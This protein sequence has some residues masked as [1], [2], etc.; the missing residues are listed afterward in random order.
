MTSGPGLRKWVNA[1]PRA[2]VRSLGNS[3][4]AVD[5]NCLSQDLLRF[6]VTSKWQCPEDERGLLKFKS[7]ELH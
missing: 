4:V 3:Q 2:Q 1:V 5:T 7:S 6:E